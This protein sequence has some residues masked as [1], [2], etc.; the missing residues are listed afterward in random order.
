MISSVTGVT[1]VCS[2]GRMAR[3]T[4]PQLCS[5]DGCDLPRYGRGWCRNHYAHWYRHG[6]PIVPRPRPR[7]DV[8]ERFWEKVN[9]SGD[10]C[11]EWTAALDSSGYGHFVIDGR[12]YAASR[13]AWMLT[14]GPI[15]DGMLVCHHCDNRVCCRPDHLFL[16][17][18]KDNTQDGV[19]KGRITGP[20]IR[21]HCKRGHELTEDNV[22][23]YG[24]KRKCRTCTRLRRAQARRKAA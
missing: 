22:Y 8:G 13:V 15:A 23:R 24:G 4:T 12:H 10:D 14:H 11:W 9:R 21:T 19:R 5:I 6:D 16:G 3:H 7:R 2:A 18:A 20:A 17:T 1:P